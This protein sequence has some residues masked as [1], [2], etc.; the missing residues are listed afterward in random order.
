MSALSWA[1]SDVGRV[2]LV[3]VALGVL[4]TI[5]VSALVRI[6]RDCRELQ[7]LA[8]KLHLQ[9]GAIVGMLLRA[10]FR[11]APRGRDWFDDAHETQAQGRGSRY[12][13]Q[14]DPFAPWKR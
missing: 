8:A 2:A 12:D 4:V 5:T 1:S 13:T 3:L 9:Q 6:D 7:K 10:G 11:P 14:V